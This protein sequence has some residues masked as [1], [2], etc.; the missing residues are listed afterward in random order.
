MAS[1]PVPD[2]LRAKE[3]VVNPNPALMTSWNTRATEV[4]KRVVV[5]DANDKK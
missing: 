5:Y 3:Q 1:H 4:A 2:R